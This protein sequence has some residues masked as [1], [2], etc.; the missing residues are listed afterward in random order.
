MLGKAFITKKENYITPCMF[1]NKNS[2]A[3]SATDI[4]TSTQQYLVFMCMN[5]LHQN[6]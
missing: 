5:Y 6:V 2:T 1:L 4:F 3:F